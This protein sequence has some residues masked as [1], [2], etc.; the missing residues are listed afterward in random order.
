MLLKLKAE[1]G[2][3]WD[4]FEE[5]LG[6]TREGCDD[7]DILIGSVQISLIRKILDRVIKHIPRRI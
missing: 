7:P 1:E 5:G 2:E 4:G 6:L 3:G